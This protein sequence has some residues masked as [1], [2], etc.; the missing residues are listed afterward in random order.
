MQNNDNHA[1]VTKVSGEDTL[2]NYNNDMTTTNV[3]FGV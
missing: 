3:D 1:K 2:N